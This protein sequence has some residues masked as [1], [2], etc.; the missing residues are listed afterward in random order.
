MPLMD[1]TLGRFPV[2]CVDIV[3]PKPRFISI[4][5]H[6]FRCQP[7]W[8]RPAGIALVV[9][10]GALALVSF[11]VLAIMTLTR[12]ENV[13]SNHQADLNEVQLL[14]ELPPQLV[15]SQIRNATSRLGQSLTWTSQPGLIRVFGA[16]PPPVAPSPTEPAPRRPQ[17][18]YPLY[19]GRTLYSDAAF[20]PAAEAADIGNWGGAVALFVDLNEPVFARPNFSGTQSG[21]N[22]QPLLFPIL[23]PVAIDPAFSPQTPRVAG[24]RFTGPTAGNAAGG[25]SGGNQTGHPLPMPVRW[26]YVLSNGKLLVPRANSSPTVARLDR[27]EFNPRADEP[28]PRIIGRIAFWT[29]D[30]SCKL[31]LNTASEPAPW[32]PPHSS[33]PRDRWAADSQPVQNEAHRLAGHPAFTALSPVMRSFGGSTPSPVLQPQTQ[34]ANGGDGIDPLQQAFMTYLENTRRLLPGRWDALSGSQNGAV[35]VDDFTKLPEWQLPSLLTHPHEW[36]FDTGVPFGMGVQR[37]RRGYNV[38]GGYTMDEMDIRRAQFCVTT[39]NTAPETNPFNLPKISLWPVQRDLPQRTR[40][41]QLMTLAASLGPGLGAEK[42]FYGIQ[43]AAS[44]SGVNSPGSSQSLNDDLSGLQRNREVYEYL[45]S[46]TR[47]PLP[48][49]G[50]SF[51]N[52]YGAVN[53]DKLL[54]NFIDQIRW[55]SNPG[56]ASNELGPRYDFLIPPNRSAPNPGAA[57]VMPLQA[58]VPGSGTIRSM[59]RFPTITEVAMVFVATDAEKDGSGDVRPSDEDPNFAKKVTEVR[60]FIVLEPFLTAP[61]HPAAFPKLR[62]VLKQINDTESAFSVNGVNLNFG[63]SADPIDLTLDT[64][65]S[66]SFPDPRFPGV[67]RSFLGGDALAYSGIISQ[68][69]REDGSPRIALAV[70]QPV[71]QYPFFSR[72]V[73]IDINPDPGTPQILPLL[74]GNLQIEIRNALTNELFQTLTIPFSSFN[75]ASIPIPKMPLEAFPAAGT[76]ETLLERFRPIENP[77]LGGPPYLKVIRPGD[78]VRSVEFKA[79]APH[80]GDTRLLA[81]TAQVP[82][83]WFTPNVASQ[84]VFQAHSLREGLY[85]QWGGNGT[86]ASSQ[87]GLSG[88]GLTDTPKEPLENLSPLL[89]GA[90]VIPMP[91][92]VQTLGLPSTVIDA[93]SPGAM[94]SSAA[95]LRYGDW[96]TG[97]GN[98]PDGAYHARM[99]FLN[100]SSQAEFRLAAAGGAAAG[101]GAA[102][103][104]GGQMEQDVTGVSHTPLRQLRSAVIF[105]AL[106]PWQ[107]DSSSPQPD[108]PE[109][110][111]RPAVQPW[112]T[113]LFCPNPASRITP[114]NQ[115]PTPLD[116]PGFANPPDHLWLDFFW[117]PVVEPRLLSSGFATEGKVNLN[118]GMVPF[119][120]IERSTAMHGVLHGVRVPAIPSS[121]AQIYKTPVDATGTAVEVPEFHYQVN[122]DATLEAFR[123]RFRQG[124]VFTQPSDICEVFMVPQRLPGKERDYDVNLPN[125]LPADPAGLA[126][127]AAPSETNTLVNWWDGDNTNSPLDADAFELTGDNLRESPYDQIINRICTRSNVFKVHY[128]VQLLTKARSGEPNEWDAATE[129]VRAELRGATVIERY[130]DPNDPSIP[131]FVT[132]NPGGLALDDFYRYRIVRREPFT[133]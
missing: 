119:N 26:L 116:H 129:R 75:G 24:L 61:G 91:A 124:E 31:N 22:Q 80:L 4:Q 87:L 36:L 103:T 32:L 14:A 118:F 3:M 108:S 15:I 2:E 81:A 57:S 99:D 120:W 54:L 69:V 125:P 128:R 84:D 28:A 131:D 123:Q 29:D 59:G 41:D 50:E 107:F 130:L 46:Q 132:A 12:N 88:D 48:G 104:L 44:W 62:Y 105:G 78:V 97:Y 65:F 106:S 18:C 63:N 113:L 38:P 133:P 53:C 1:S 43:R 42:P 20:D 100:A 51:Q 39:Y 47:A 101:I 67:T 83:E 76:D 40:T 114:A 117:M 102:Y 58:N 56:N 8:R 122:A 90:F 5:P 25:G 35:A 127:A 111:V 94:P 30:E 93:A 112:R 17:L 19:S 89:A 37:L 13:A 68:F 64:G 92:L 10:M 121:A 55:I 98:L 86:P 110:S 79:T 73:K 23:D 11:L 66:Y 74:A 85:E 27:S 9:V 109:D 7:L 126:L 72:G 34:P 21:T 96:E 71:E 45:R 16:D 95:N 60:A 82:P 77:V 115:A 6:L 70:D 49:Y 52:K 33:S